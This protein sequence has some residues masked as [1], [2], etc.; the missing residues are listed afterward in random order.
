MPVGT[1]RSLHFKTR[2]IVLVL[3]LAILICVYAALLSLKNNQNT[4]TIRHK[5]YKVSVANSPEER[6]RGL[7]GRESMPKQAGMLFTFEQAG[8]HC[9]WM[10]DMRINIDILWF[11]T[12]KKLIDKQLNASPESYPWSFCPNDDALYVLELN[13]GEAKDIKIADRISF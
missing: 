7:S 13:A 4:V 11:D 8:R 9:F 2:Y 6:E 3:G 1:V 10:K 12:N 5:S